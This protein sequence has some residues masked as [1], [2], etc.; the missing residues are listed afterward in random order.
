MSMPNMQIN[1]VNVY[2]EVH[3][4]GEPLLLI[5][6]FSQ[7]VLGWFSQIAAYS[8]FYK[9]IV[10]DHRGV[11]RTEAPD[12]P[13]SMEMMADDAAGLMAGLG[14]EKA[15]VI[16][17]SL[18]G[19]IAQELALKYPARISSLVLVSTFASPYYPGLY[20]MEA[21]AKMLQEGISQETYFQFLLLWIN[22]EKFF[23]KPERV[24]KAI[25]MMMANP[26]PQSAR[27]MFQ[28]LDA[29]RQQPF[30]R[31]RLGQITAPALV[32]AGKQ[33]IL[34][35]VKMSEEIAA[36]I[37]NA[38]LVVLDGAAHGIV[39]E[40]WREFNQVVLDFLATAVKR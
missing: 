19:M 17:W 25:E 3:G 30:T 11:G 24:Q 21:G 16:G 32:I 7:D 37:N 35:P 36:G 18:G 20:V 22:S 34:M 38:R 9:V 15:H 10:Y 40:N 14:I 5:G 4:E 29:F 6:G 1:D 13:W 2:Y 28:L 23:E 31:D 39:M 8:R 26:Y 27:A 33:D 12:V